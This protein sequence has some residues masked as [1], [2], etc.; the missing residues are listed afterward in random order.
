MKRQFKLLV[1]WL[2]LPFLGYSSEGD[3]NHSKQK[4]INKAFI[5]NP[6]ATL[7]VNNSYG[8]VSITTW[9]EDKVELDI[10]IK[11]SGNSEKWVNQRIN[12]IDVDINALKT[13]I[14][15]STILGNSGYHNQG[16]NNSFEINYVL[17]IPKNGSI[18]ISNKYGNIITSD[19]YA[20]VDVNCKY[21]KVIMGKLWNNSEITMD[22][23]PNSIIAFIK[24]GTIAAKYSSLTITEID[25][26]DLIS[27][28][29]DVEIM[30]CDYLKYSSKYGKIAIKSIKSLEGTGNY[31]TIRLAKLYNYLKLNTKYSSLQIETVDERVK[32][33]SIV[34][35]YT[36]ITIGFDANFAFNFSISLKYANFIFGNELDFYAKEEVSNSKKYIGFYKK[37]D[38]NNLS[39]VSDY[40]NVALT[41]ND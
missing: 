21:G 22:Y 6:D 17:K 35:Q 4:N 1:L 32:T 20:T 19:L 9:N 7:V 3:Y 41:K 8:N 30:K 29:T 16:R 2:L 14:S 31:L 10:N 23:C 37:K 26:L 13:M 39:I 28:Y 5:V 12:D 38:S 34:S 11:V 33:I 18:K 25:K 27:D 40:G 24:T 15:V 36:G